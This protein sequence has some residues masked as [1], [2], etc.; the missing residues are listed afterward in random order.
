MCEEEVSKEPRNPWQTLVSRRR[1]RR[2]RR[3]EACSEQM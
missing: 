2:R 3:S 1:Q